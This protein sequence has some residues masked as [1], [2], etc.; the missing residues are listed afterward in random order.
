MSFDFLDCMSL[1]TSC[2]LMLFRLILLV[3]PLEQSPFDCTVL[4]SSA[5]VVS[6]GQPGTLCYVEIQPCSL[7]YLICDCTLITV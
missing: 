3:Q 2:M 1:A 5:A 6:G 4:Y 7:D